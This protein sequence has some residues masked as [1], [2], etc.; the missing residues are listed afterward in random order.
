MTDLSVKEHLRKSFPY[1]RPLLP[2]NLLDKMKSGALFGYVQRGNTV[3]EHL[4]EQ[5]VNYRQ[6][7]KEQKYVDKSMDH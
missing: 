7:S 6:H 4:R 5:L 1:K 2:D 3:P